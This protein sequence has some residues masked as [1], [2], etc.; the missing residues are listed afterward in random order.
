M[1][2]V[3]KD[4]ERTF[5]EKKTQNVFQRQQGRYIKYHISVKFR[6]Y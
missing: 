3:I 1:Y 6:A 5:D 4:Q 2:N